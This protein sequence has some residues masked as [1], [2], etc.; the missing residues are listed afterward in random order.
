MALLFI[1][2]NNTSEEKTVAVRLSEL[3]INFVK[4]VTDHFPLPMGEMWKQ[5]SH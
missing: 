2:Y 5:L 3:K 1:V 4:C